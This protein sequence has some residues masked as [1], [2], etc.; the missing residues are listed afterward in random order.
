MSF[1]YDEIFDDVKKL[2]K[3]YDSRNPKEILIQRGV[4]IIAFKEN[5][6]LLGIKLSKEILLFFT[7]PLLTKEFKIWFL[8]TNWAMT[9]ITK[10]WQKMKI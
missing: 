9:F 5:T 10:I 6:K 8:L 4:N 2:I 1:L 3:K 7:I